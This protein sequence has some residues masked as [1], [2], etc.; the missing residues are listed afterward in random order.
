MLKTSY[1]ER[2]HFKMFLENLSANVLQLC[3][4]YHLSYERASERCNLSER[5]FGSIARGKT[6]PTILTLEKLCT[7]FDLT[8]NDLLIASAMQQELAYRQP[9]RS[10]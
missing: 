9:S 7:G 10:S 6:A 1:A 4:F 3:D 8:P 5:Y 2:V